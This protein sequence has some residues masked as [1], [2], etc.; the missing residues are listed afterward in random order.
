MIIDNIRGK[1]SGRCCEKSGVRWRWTK[2]RPV[3]VLLVA[4]IT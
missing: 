2:C 3:T 4:A 1:D